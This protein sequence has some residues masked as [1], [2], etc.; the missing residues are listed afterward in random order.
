MRPQI[1]DLERQ[2]LAAVEAARSSGEYRAALPRVS[3][4][5]A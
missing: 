3:V 1:E 4:Y 5:I 2:A